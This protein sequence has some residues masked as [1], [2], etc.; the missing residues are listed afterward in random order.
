MNL[1]TLLYKIRKGEGSFWR[2]VKGFLH[3]AIFFNFPAPRIVFR[4]IY[5]LLVIWRFL[6]HII[7]EKVLYVPVFKSRCN[8]CGRGLSLPNGIPWIEG[9]LRIKIGDNVQIDKN[10][11]GSG[12]TGENPTLMIGDRTHLGYGLTISV[13]NS[14][15][16]GNDCLIAGGC[17]IADNDGHP[18]DPHRRIRKEPVNEQ[19]ID[20]VVIEDNVWIGTG[21]VILKGVTI[22][23][24]SVVAA[25]SLVTRSIPPYS[26]AMGV[27]AKIIKSGIDKI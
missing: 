10:T 3:F 5:E 24:G 20:P 8:Q 15:K 16:I 6:G 21:S 4:P 19:E 27:P 25:N 1:E 9:H 14:V 18:I 23:E 2:K 7:V 17:F 26:I 11:F 12:H 22:G 13:G